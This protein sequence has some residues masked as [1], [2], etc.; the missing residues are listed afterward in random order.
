M[1]LLVP[2]VPGSLSFTRK[3]RAGRRSPPSQKSKDKARQLQ[4]TLFLSQ[5]TSEPTHLCHGL[6]KFLKSIPSI[7]E[8]LNCEKCKSMHHPEFLR[9]TKNFPTIDAEL[10]F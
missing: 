6:W 8:G 5:P 10:N 3:S 7:I 2:K 9:D 4:F 1:Q